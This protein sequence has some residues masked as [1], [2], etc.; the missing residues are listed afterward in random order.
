MYRTSEFR[1]N[2]RHNAICRKKHIAI[3]RD[4]SDW[5]NKDG[6][7]DKGKIHCGCGVCKYSKKFG[8]PTIRTERELDKFRSELEDFRKGA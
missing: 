2:A 3:K 7:Y 5:Y 6:K 4:G 8:Y 1:R